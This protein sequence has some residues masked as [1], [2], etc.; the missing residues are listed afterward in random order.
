M[1]APGEH[2]ANGYADDEELDAL[3]GRADL[4]GLVRL[5]DART[6]RRDWAGLARLRD[7]CR[8]AVLTG[9]QLWP[10]TTLAEYRLALS[11]PAAW[12]VEAINSDGGRFTVGPLTEVVAQGRTWAELGPHLELGPAAAVVMHERVLRGEDLSGDPGAASLPDPLELPRVLGAWEPTL[13]VTYHD[14]GVTADA[15]ASPGRERFAPLRTAATPGEVLDDPEVTDAVR[16]L[17]RPWVADSN[18]RAEVVCVEGSADDAVAALGVPAAAGSLAPLATVEALAWLSWTGASGGAHGRRRGGAA[19]RFG[20]WWL[21]ATLGD[22]TDDW[23]PATDELGG[24]AGSLQWSWWD[25]GEP[26]VGWRLQI[27]VHDPEAGLSWAIN[28]SDAA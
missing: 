6:E 12:A 10:A 27:A 15:P 13:E 24:F 17:V 14:N 8:A 4:D 26:P 23:P 1:N 2:A 9:R 28:A 16:D 25:A 20:M 18:G 21:L 11:A 5:V 19:G 22:L 7:R 3:V